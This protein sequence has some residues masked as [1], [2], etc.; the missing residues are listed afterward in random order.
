MRRQRVA[1]QFTYLI[2]TTFP[3][4][5]NGHRFVQFNQQT[6][7]PVPSEY[8]SQFYSRDANFCKISWGWAYRGQG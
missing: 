7:R 1:F 4:E 6:H 8:C 5:Y 3:S 2:L